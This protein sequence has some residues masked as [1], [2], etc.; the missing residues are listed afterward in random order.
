MLIYWILFFIPLT[1]ILLP[2]RLTPDARIIALFIVGVVFVL[3]IGSRHQVGGD[4]SSYIRMYNEIN[5]HALYDS[6]LLSDVGYVTLNKISFFL[7]GDVYLVNTI[8]GLIFIAGVLSFARHQPLPWMALLIAVPYLI[9]VVGMG[10]TRQSIAV[11]LVFFAFNALTDRRLFS[12]VLW[13]IVATSFHKSAIIL[14][15]LLLFFSESRNHTLIFFIGALSAVLLSLF[16]LP[17][18]YSDLIK[19]YV[20]DQYM[21]S[22]GALIRVVMNFIPSVILLVFGRSLTNTSGELKLWRAVSVISI[23]CIPLVFFASTAIDRIALYFI[24]LQLFVFSRVHMIFNSDLAKVAVITSIILYYAIIHFVWL[25]FAS[26][27][28]Y[29]LPYQTKFLI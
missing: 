2:V 21:E 7:S 12:F 25:N 24:P 26:Y 3:L 11:G 17:M 14:L 5:N 4:W 15:P 10:Y 18:G 22:S 28:T 29:W 6:L 8:S 23:L 9:T 27:S 1:T 16:L 19:Y 13:I 20:T